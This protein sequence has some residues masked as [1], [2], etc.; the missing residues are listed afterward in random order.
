MSHFTVTVCVPAERGHDYEAYCAEVLAPYDE[1]GES[2]REN[3][4]WDWWT[5]G[6]RWSG[7]FKAK[8]GAS[9]QRGERS[10][11]N[12]D[13]PVIE[14]YYDVIAKGDVDFEGMVEAKVRE[15]ATWYDGGG[16]PWNQPEIPREEVLKGAESLATHS[17]VDLNGSW[18]E[19]SQMGWF[20]MSRSEDD[21]DWESKWLNNVIAL[22]DE[23]L[24]VL[25]DCHV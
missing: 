21:G 24:L 7:Y 1:Q 17:L 12:E 15:A 9:G 25:V 10:W 8:D 23:D 2:F 19:V 22:A 20:G 14:G 13:E 16:R 18:L 6:G 4:H 5:V 3:T 11:S